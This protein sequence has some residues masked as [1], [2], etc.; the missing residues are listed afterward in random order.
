MATWMGLEG[1][2]LILAIVGVIGIVLVDVVVEQT[3][4]PSTFVFELFECVDGDDGGGRVAAVHVSV[5]G[6]S[7]DF[8]LM[9]VTA[10]A[11]PWLKLLLKKFDFDDGLFDVD[12]ADADDVDADDVILFQG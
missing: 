9:G 1:S 5:T 8:T 4:R 3:V 6:Q 11:E 7:S 2:C 12:E 10:G